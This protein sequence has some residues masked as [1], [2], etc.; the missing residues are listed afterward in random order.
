MTDILKR[1]DEHIEF[2]ESI[3]SHKSDVAFLNTIREHIVRKDEELQEAND[4]LID[5]T[6]MNVPIG[7]YALAQHYVNKHKNALKR[8]MTK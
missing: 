1:I 7:Y 8:A 6:S 5:W 2:H 4:A 3:D